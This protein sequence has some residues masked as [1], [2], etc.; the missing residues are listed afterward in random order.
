MSK[1]EFIGHILSK[2]GIG[3]TRSKIKDVENTHQPTNSAEVRSFLGLV[4][5][6][7][8]FVLRRKEQERAKEIAGH[9][10]WHISNKMQRSMLL[11]M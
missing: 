5:Y 9:M 6:F 11:W 1:L 3:A 8:R 4:N 2:N 10:S 7:G